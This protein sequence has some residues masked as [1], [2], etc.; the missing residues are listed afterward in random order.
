M[1]DIEGL[2]PIVYRDSKIYFLDQTLLPVEKKYIEIDSIE[3]CFKAIERLEVRGAPAIGIAAAYGFYLSASLNIGY[4]KD[5]FIRNVKKDKKYLASSR[6]TAVNL[7]WALDR[8]EKLFNSLLDK[9]PNFIL[10]GLEKEARGIQLEEEEACKNIGDIGLEILEDGMGI[11]THCNAGALATS[12]YGTALAPI[13][14]GKEKG[15]E[16]K[17][18]VDETRPLLQG[19]RL[20]AYE[21]RENKIDTTIITDSMAALLMK[22]GRIDLVIVGCDRAASNG[23]VAN[24]IGTYNLAVL[25]YYHKIPFYVAVPTSTFDISL[26]SGREIP[27]EERAGDEIIKGFGKQTGPDGVKVYNPAFDVTPYYLIDGIITEK[28]IIREPYK[29]NIK[30]LFK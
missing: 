19:S 28:G 3:K 4:D 15:M 29:K 23:D 9:N 17:V 11:L 20:T 25:A 24:K 27:I 10:L 26:E 16:F 14:R 5:I 12:K 30:K 6:P 13:Y 7:F 18:F 1:E 2:R 8:M 22:E 21:L